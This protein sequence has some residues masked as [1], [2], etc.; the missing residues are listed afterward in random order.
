MHVEHNITIAAAPARI[1]RIWQ[2][3]ANW[4]TWDPDTRSAS[5]D[6]PFAVGSRGRLTPTK[7]ASVAMVLTSVVPDRS[8]TVESRIPL[9]HMVFEHALQPGGS[10]TTEVLHRVRFFGLLAPLIGRLIARQLQVGLP[11]TLANLKRLAEE[12]AGR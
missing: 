5:L 8:F 6:G 3:V 1:F 2:D 4:H 7:G 12:N 11:R 10:T 9:F